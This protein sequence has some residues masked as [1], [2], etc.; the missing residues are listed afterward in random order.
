MT[1]PTRPIAISLA[2]A[3][4]M[5]LVAP[6]SHAGQPLKVTLDKAEVLP[7]KD[8]ASVVLVANPQIADVVLERGKLLFV[9]GKREGETRLYVYGDQGQRLLE[10]DIV[11]VPR[12]ERTVTVMRGTRPMD[13]AC[14]GRCTAVGAAGDAPNEVTPA[15]APQPAPQ[16]AAPAP[17]TTPAP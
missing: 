15:A 8:A 16:G 11:V 3:V 5:L 12:H 13:Y 14:D 7:L 2:A 10:R 6:P 4:A 17:A 9:L 1:N